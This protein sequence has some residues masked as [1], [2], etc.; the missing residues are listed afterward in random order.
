M[1][2]AMVDRLL[3]HGHVVTFKGESYRIRHAL[4]NARAKGGDDGDD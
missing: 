4:M 3:H 1:A 2:S